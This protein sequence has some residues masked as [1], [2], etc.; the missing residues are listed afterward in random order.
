MK[1]IN[2]TPTKS[3]YEFSESIIKELERIKRPFN[4]TE[5][6]QWEVNSHI[7]MN[8]IFNEYQNKGVI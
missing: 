6:V 8:Y 3:Q 2:F 4:K 7:V 5:R 1:N